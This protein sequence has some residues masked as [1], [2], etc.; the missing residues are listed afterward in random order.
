MANVEL[1]HYTGAGRPDAEWHAADL[2]IFTKNTRL[3]MSGEGLS[4][5]K[6]WPEERK[7]AEL[8][9]MAGT[10]PS[11]WEFA[12]LVFA[13]RGV[14]RAT[15]QQMT[16]TR[17]ASFAQQSQRVADLEGVDVVNPFDPA[18]EPAEHEFFEHA[19]GGSLTA[20]HQLVEGGAPKEDARGLLPMNVESTIVCKYNLRTFVDLVRARESIRAQG[21]YRD[22]V[23]DMKRLVLDAW[24]W[25]APFFESSHDKALA[26]LEEVAHELGITPG[27]GMAWKIAKAVDLI[28]KGG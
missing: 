25:A 16:R 18:A 11:S 7:R 21:E 20:Y 10:I 27:E 22:V 6:A 28:R 9:Y 14:S 12:E 24:P 19:A 2:L 4:A 8:E 23:A 17:T 13:V 1:I 3:T 5:I 15:T 26:M